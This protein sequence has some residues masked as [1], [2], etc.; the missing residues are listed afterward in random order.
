MKT[1]P[2]ALLALSAAVG[3][4]APVEAG[5]PGGS[6]PVMITPADG[7]T[8]VGGGTCAVTTTPGGTLATVSALMSLGNQLTNNIN[9]QIA[10]ASQVNDA[11]LKAVIKAIEAS[12][13]EL[14]KHIQTS[15]L[16][17]HQTTQAVE[18]ALTYD[19]KIGNPSSACGSRSNAVALQIGTAANRQVAG[20]FTGEMAD[21]RNRWATEEQI[22]DA[23]STIDGEKISGALL[24][25]PDNTVSSAAPKLPLSI[26]ELAIAPDP[27]VN[28]SEGA[29]NTP[30]GRD[31]ENTR[32]VVAIKKA[33][34]DAVMADIVAAHQPTIHGMEAQIRQMW[35]QQGG[36]SNMDPPGLQPDGTISRAAYQALWVQMFSANPNWIGSLPGRKPETLLRDLAYMRAA[37][38]DMQ[39]EELRLLR[40]IA[41]MLAIQQAQQVDAYYDEQLE[42]QR[43]RA[44][45]SS[46][47]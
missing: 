37:E 25:P 19:A 24:F 34:A 1:L 46:T 35:A 17:A 14:G 40:Q 43:R 18:N 8:V 9:S 28:L 33:A 23:I 13:N 20:Y 12:T 32:T 45:S 7:A 22:A 4:V 29:K 6:M 30:A 11:N 31:Y 26:A 15:I 38:L 16:T 41:A 5:I 27:A 21:H 44:V 42:D 39:L 36:S 3:L 47:N 10:A 2:R